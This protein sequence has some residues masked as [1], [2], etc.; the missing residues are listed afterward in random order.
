MADCQ[1]PVWGCLKQHCNEHPHPLQPPGVVG[2]SGVQECLCFAWDAW[3]LAGSAT[4]TSL[5]A[6]RHASHTHVCPCLVAEVVASL[7]PQ[8][9]GTTSPDPF[10]S[11]PLTVPSSKPSGARKTPESFLGPNAALVNLDSLVTRPAP[12]AQSLNPFLAPGTLA[13]QGCLCGCSS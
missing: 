11:Q 13:S 6:A 3:G 1:S 12:P 5:G 7:P 8:N 4:C 9:N 10:E 2:G